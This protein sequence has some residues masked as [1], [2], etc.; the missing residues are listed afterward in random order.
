[1]IGPADQSDDMGAF[2]VFDLP[3]G[4]YYVSAARRVA[5]I[6]SPNDTTFAP[7]Y[8]PGTASLQAALRVPLGPAEEQSVSFPLMPVRTV[9]VSGVVLHADSTPP[10]RAYVNL[11][12]TASDTTVNTIAGADAGPDG[13]F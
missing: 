4:E 10:A 12:A 2:R 1:Q 8:F 6:D 9:R 5:P 11:I 3:A 7:T 13:T